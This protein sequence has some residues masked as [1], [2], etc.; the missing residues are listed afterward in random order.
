MIRYITLTVLICSLSFCSQKPEKSEQSKI[1]EIEFDLTASDSNLVNPYQIQLV[2]ESLLVVNDLYQGRVGSLRKTKDLSFQ[3]RIGKIGE[4]PGELLPPV[5]ITSGDGPVLYLYSRRN[6]NVLKYDAKSLTSENVEPL[7]EFRSKEPLD[8]ILMLND[9]SMVGLG[10]SSEKKRYVLVSDFGESSTL[11]DLDYPAYPGL[12][13]EYNPMAFQANLSLR[14]DQRAFVT[15][16][17]FCKHFEIIETQEGKRLAKRFEFDQLDIKWVD[18]SNGDFKQI[19]YLEEHEAGFINV[20]ST[21][22]YIY[23]LYSGRKKGVFKEKAFL[24]NTILVYDWNGELV[25]QFNLNV[26]L[27]DLAVSESDDYIYGLVR[28]RE[29]ALVRFS[30]NSL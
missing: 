11:A 29:P 22:R 9:S 6:N 5:L 2:D 3:G 17:I 19:G 16:S 8:K 14:P 1:T 13:A 26:D 28:D 25:H 30:I 7:L 10:F 18:V 12:P 20:A 21:Q 15:A 24:A 4:G 27:H 23:L